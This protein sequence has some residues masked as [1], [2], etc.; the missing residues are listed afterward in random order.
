M[1]SK[2][3]PLLLSLLVAVSSLYAQAPEDEITWDDAPNPPVVRHIGDW[4]ADSGWYSAEEIYGPF[5]EDHFEVGD[6]AEFGSAA[7]EYESG[8]STYVLRYKSDSAYFW[9]PPDYPIDEAQL[10]T[11]AHYF[12]DVIQPSV[13]SIFG[14]EDLP[15]IDDDIHL[16]IV[17]QE[18]IGYGAIG[19]FRPDDQCPSFLCES[20]NQRDIIYYSLD[21]SGV[22]TDGHL[23]TLAFV[24]IWMV[25]NAAG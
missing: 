3:A 14:D 11:A 22:N 12:D 18:Y 21:W 23:T 19:V 20:S 7:A 8:K 16:H 13:R 25:M 1:F 2:A 9:F 6:E 15:G 4:M 5:A 10:T 17:H 24:T